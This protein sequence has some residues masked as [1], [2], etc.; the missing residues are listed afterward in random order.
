MLQ[1]IFEYRLRAEVS[2][3]RNR[4]MFHAN[5]IKGVEMKKREYKFERLNM[6]ELRRL[7]RRQ[8]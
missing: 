8:L 2:L 4:S 6:P 1:T 5:G 7:Y 3:K